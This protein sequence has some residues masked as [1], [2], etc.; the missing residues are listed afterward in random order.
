M[1][2]VFSLITPAYKPSQL[3]LVDSCQTKNGFPHIRNGRAKAQDKSGDGKLKVS[4]F[5]PLF[6]P[7]L[8]KRWVLAL[9]PEYGWAL[10]GTPNRKHLWVYSRT[11]SMKP[12]VLREVEA[13]A[14]AEGFSV[15]R[16]T[17]T[18]QTAR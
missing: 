6:W 12:E 3:L 2:D 9:G 11:R 13:R 18:P 7:F 5:F 17:V 10:V 15:A 8:E 14:E 1:G 4:Y 16:L